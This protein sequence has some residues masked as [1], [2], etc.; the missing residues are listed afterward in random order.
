MRVLDWTV[1]EPMIANNKSVFQALPSSFLLDLGKR[2][3]IPINS[4]LSI[5]PAFIEP[6]KATR[7]RQ[8]GPV[9]SLSHREAL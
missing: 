9:G 5:C 2:P 1:F 6:N 8:P 4:S 3:F 7:L